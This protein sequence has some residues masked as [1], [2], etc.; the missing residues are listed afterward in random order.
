MK[1]R[2]ICV[3]K[4]KEPFYRNQIQEY[5]KEIRKTHS[6]EILEVEDEKT[7]EHLSDVEREKILRLEGDR[8]LRALASDRRDY[9]VPLCIDGIP[10][11]TEAWKTHIHSLEEM[12]EYEQ[13]TYIIGG[14]LGLSEE[15]ICKGNKRLSYSRLTFPH[16]LMRVMVLEQI[17]NIYL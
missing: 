6:I 2:I 14:S 10:Y 15:V 5:L 3:G 9:I 1:N 7:K 16:Q 11:D 8:I 17:R 4:V 13:I 12:G